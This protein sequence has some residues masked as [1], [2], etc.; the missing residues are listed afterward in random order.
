[1]SQLDQQF[2]DVNIS[3]SGNVNTIYRCSSVGRGSADSCETDRQEAAQR[4]RCTGMVAAVM[5][6]R[7]LYHSATVRVLQTGCTPTANAL[8]VAVDGKQNTRVN[9]TVTNWE[10]S[11]RASLACIQP[12][13]ITFLKQKRS[14]S[15]RLVSQARGSSKVNHGS[16]NN[17]DPKN[18]D[19]MIN[20]SVYP[21]WLNRGLQV[22]YMWIQLTTF[23]AD[24]AQTRSWWLDFFHANSKAVCTHDNR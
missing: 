13:F 17:D 16:I 10:D 6:G 7:I 4:N 19:V 11:N 8:F 14:R 18:V 9:L 24:F 5:G 12:S 23:A 3:C 22:R 15:Q 21:S 20:F 1:M 2:R